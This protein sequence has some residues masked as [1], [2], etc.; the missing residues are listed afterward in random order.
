[1][2]KHL[3]LLFIT[4]LCLSSSGIVKGEGTGNS[5]PVTAAEAAYT[6]DKLMN[7]IDSQ[8]GKEVKVRGTVNH[9]C[10]H[11]GKK[12]FIM[13]DDGKL[14][15]QIMAGGEI[16]TFEKDLIGSE[17]EAVGVVKERRMPKDDIDNNEKAAHEKMHEGSES[18]E[19]CEAMLNNVKEMRAWMEKNNKDY[20]AIY[21][22]DGIKYEVVD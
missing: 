1:M 20:F 19:H 12:C 22:V 15:L 2:Y 18:K 4:V 3:V 14:S 6:I 7:V 5:S 21:Y 13:N 16:T 17:I 10:K 11:S 9:V 8:V